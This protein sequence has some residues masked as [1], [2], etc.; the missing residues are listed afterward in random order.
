MPY[1]A[2]AAAHEG[3][4]LADGGRAELAG[5]VAEAARAIEIDAVGAAE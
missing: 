5:E 4:M 1:L 3:D 2:S